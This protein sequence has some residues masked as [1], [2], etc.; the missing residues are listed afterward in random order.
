MERFFALLDGG[1]GAWGVVFPDCPGCTAM[2][3]DE[4]EAYENAVE[5]L[6]EWMHDM[7]ADGV[8]PKPR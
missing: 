3:A 6:G 4:N 1:P 2:G 8:E 5:A 7:R